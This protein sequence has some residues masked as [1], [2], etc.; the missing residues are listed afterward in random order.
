LKISSQ[1]IT[2]STFHF[3]DLIRFFDTFASNIR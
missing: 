2:A 3:R 1:V